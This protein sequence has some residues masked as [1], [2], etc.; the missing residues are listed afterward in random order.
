MNKLT[1]GATRLLVLVLGLGLA[2]TGWAATPVAEWGLGDFPVSAAG[3]SSDKT[4]T[5]GDYTIDKNNNY[6]ISTANYIQVAPSS[7]GGG[8]PIVISG[9]DLSALTVVVAFSL[10]ED[11]SGSLVCFS[12]YL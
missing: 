10:D 5:S 4:A 3:N 1:Q 7:V 2:A 8:W 6:N 9:T 12:M 11:A